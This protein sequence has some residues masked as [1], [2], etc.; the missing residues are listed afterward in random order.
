VVNAVLLRPLPFPQGE[1]LV[2]L[3]ESSARAN[4]F[5]VTWVNFQR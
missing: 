3:G 5:S 1:R 2:R 4:G